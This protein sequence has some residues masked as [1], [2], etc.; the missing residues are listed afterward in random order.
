MMLE[1]QRIKQIRKMFVKK[2]LENLILD[3]TKIGEGGG[4]TNRS[5]LGFS[6]SVG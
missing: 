2:N 4:G 6:W 3:R 1:M 5:F